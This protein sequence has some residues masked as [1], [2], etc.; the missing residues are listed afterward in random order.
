ME[1]AK[2]DAEYIKDLEKRN[3]ILEGKNVWVGVR[4]Y[5]DNMLATIQPFGAPEN[6]TQ[7]IKFKGYGAFAA[8]PADKW[9]SMVRAALHEDPEGS[10][11]R[12]GFFARDDESGRGSGKNF[13][14]DSYGE[15]IFTNAILD[16]EI[17]QLYSGSDEKFQKRL[18]VIDEQFVLRRFLRIGKKQK[19]NPL[20]KME[21]VRSR[22]KEV[23]SMEMKL[24]HIQ[25]LDP[26]ALLALADKWKFPMRDI[27]FDPTDRS[28]NT[29]SQIVNL[30]E[31]LKGYLNDIIAR[32]TYDEE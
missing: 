4:H 11:I 5:T 10:D 13:I 21:M 3:A 30:R 29:A 1:K 31:R 6:G 22:M 7:D 24:D 17:Q 18:G 2:A 20:Q 25:S 9:E 32:T 28:P 16:K 12:R 19:D 15:E 8:I 27:Y 23:Q 14:E 26:H